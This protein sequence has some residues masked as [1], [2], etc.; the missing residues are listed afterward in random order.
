MEHEFDGIL[1]LDIDGVLNTR[2]Y[3]TRIYPLKSMQ[4]N[5]K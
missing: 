3:M 5:I 1:F 2:M 4:K